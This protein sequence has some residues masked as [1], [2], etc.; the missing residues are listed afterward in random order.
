MVPLRFDPV[1][2]VGLM[3]P[4]ADVGLHARLVRRLTSS[5]AAVDVQPE[6]LFE[7]M[8]EQVRVAPCR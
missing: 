6:D 3:A 4:P 1:E 8:V 5:V 7:G 2:M